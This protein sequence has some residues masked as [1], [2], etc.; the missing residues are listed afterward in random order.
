MGDENKG[1]AKGI[2]KSI[3]EIIGSNTILKNKKPSQENIQREIFEKIILSLETAEVKNIILASEFAIN[4]SNYN[5][6]YYT[7]IDGLLALHFG[8]EIYELIMFYLYD[9]M[10]PDGSFNELEDSEGNVI[11]LMSP[12]DLWD[13]I[14]KIQSTKKKK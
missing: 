2:K 14:T 5:E 13:L 6:H 9:R 1:H 10:N 11:T 4:L 3:E 8:N 12:N 7:A